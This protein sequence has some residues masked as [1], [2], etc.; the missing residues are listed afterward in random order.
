MLNSK[1]NTMLIPAPETAVSGFF[2]RAFD[3]PKSALDARATETFNEKRRN[4]RLG[5]NVPL[6]LRDATGRP[7]YSL[8]EDVSKGGFCFTSEGFYFP[9][10]VIWVEIRCGSVGQTI[11]AQ[12]RIVHRAELGITGRRLYGAAYL[13]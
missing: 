2:Q 11:E 10:E 9:G 13:C 1:E 6:T 3:V 4:P 12:A 5:F 8:T 7:E